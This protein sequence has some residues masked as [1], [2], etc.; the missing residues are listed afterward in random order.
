MSTGPAGAAAG[1]LKMPPAKPPGLTVPGYEVGGPRNPQGAG[2]ELHGWKKVL[3]VIGS[4]FPIGRAIEQNI[5]GSPQNF[6]AKFGQAAARGAREEAFTKGQQEIETAASVAQF[7]T[8]EKRRDYMNQHPDLFEDVTDF[9][10]HDFVLAGKFPQR[11]PVA[12]KDHAK[13][14]DLYAD[15][16]KKAVSEG[17]DPLADPDVKHYGDAIQ[18][19]QREPVGRGGNE[20][21]FTVWRKQHPNADV[22][23]YFKLQPEAR[24]EARPPKE[25]HLTA[26]QKAA[27]NRRYQKALDDIEADRRARASGTYVHPHSGEL[28]EPMT[29]EELQQRKQRAE[30][31]YKNALEA[32]GETNVRRFN[33][34]TGQYEGGDGSAQHQVGDTVMYKG[35]PHRIAS[36]QGGKAQ[37]VPIPPGTE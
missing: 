5:P 34:R 19:I 37:I 22:K 15:A 11:E 25:S 23:D 35:K 20:T 1:A 27:E 31:E 7:N 18:S 28:M 14:A 32:G 33:Y 17:R 29:D 36:I 16:V 13:L 4:M 9:Q 12:A 21:P 10:K 3:D 6:S 26:G 24:N 8:P 2:P 30:E